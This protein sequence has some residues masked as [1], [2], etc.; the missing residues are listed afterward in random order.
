MADKTGGMSCCNLASLNKAF[1]SLY[2]LDQD[3]TITQSLAMQCCKEQQWLQQD[4]KPNCQGMQQQQ[5][6]ARVA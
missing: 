2:T 3:A 6:A 4:A 1:S 5:A